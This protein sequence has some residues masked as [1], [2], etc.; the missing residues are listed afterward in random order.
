VLSLGRAALPG[1]KRFDLVPVLVLVGL[2]LA[3]LASFWL[4]PAFMYMMKH[5]D[6]VASGR[7]DC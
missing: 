2:V 3:V 4:V 5:Q 7:M 6:C 1:D